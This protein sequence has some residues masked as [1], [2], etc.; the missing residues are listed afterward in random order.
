MAEP[1]PYEESYLSGA[2]PSG[3]ASSFELTP[4]LADPVENPAG[5]DPEGEDAAEPDT[6]TGVDAPFLRFQERVQRLPEQV[7]RCARFFV[8]GLELETEDFA[9]RFY[10]LPGVEQPEP[11]WISSTKVLP[12]QVPACPLCGSPRDIEFQVRPFATFK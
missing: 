8:F 4:S 11:L 9:R 5:D 10:R 1:E 6:S 3:S 7:L 2:S 12:A